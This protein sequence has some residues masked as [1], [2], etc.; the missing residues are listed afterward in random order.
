M[1]IF[2]GNVMT[3][4]TSGG[5][6]IENGVI[7]Q[8]QGATAT[9]LQNAFSEYTTELSMD[10]G[11]DQADID[12]ISRLTGQFAQVYSELPVTPPTT[13]PA[14]TSTPAP[15]ATSTPAAATHGNSGTLF[16]QLHDGDVAKGLEKKYGVQNGMWTD[17]QQAKAEEDLSHHVN[18]QT[19]KIDQRSKDELKQEFGIMPKADSTPAPAATSTPAPA[20]TST[21]A[22]AATSTPAPA[23]T[24][25][26]APVATSTPVATTAPANTGTPLLDNLG[27]Q[28]GVKDLLK[29]KFGGLDTPEEKQQAE[30]YLR[31][32]S[33]DSDNVFGGVV[34]DSHD[35]NA[36]QYGSEFD[37]LHKDL[38]GGTWSDAN[39]VTKE[40]DRGS[41]STYSYKDDP[42]ITTRLNDIPA[43]TNLGNQYGIKDKLDAKLAAAKTPEEANKIIDEF[44]GFDKD[45]NNSIN[46]FEGA[47]TDKD[48][49]PVVI[50]DSEA[51]KLL[52]WLGVKPLYVPDVPPGG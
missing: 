2:K 13:A 16:N 51:D 11:L 38:T 24:S 31:K 15:A 3:K 1:Q 17:E 25:T 5:I 14:A 21:P 43:Y 44:K 40:G 19:G 29:G 6:T 46:G 28:F 49:N 47:L 7:T 18:P 27:N 42:A 22:P 52:Q 9:D 30:E 10:G 4:V 48:G 8:G 26:P 34:K 20:A 12:E 37:A 45:G 39:H 36:I 23:A 41:H 35:Q 32:F 50:P 33:K